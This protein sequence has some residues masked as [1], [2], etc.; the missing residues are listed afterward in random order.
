MLDEMAIKK[1]VSW[2]GTRYV[3]IGS[4]ETDDDDSLPVAKDALVFMVVAI[5]SSWKVPIAYFLLMV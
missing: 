4:N 1:N 2:D 3:D 5:N